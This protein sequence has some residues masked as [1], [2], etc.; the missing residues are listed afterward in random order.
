ME[1]LASLHKHGYRFLEKI[2]AG[3]SS[4]V[5]KVY[6]LKFA[7]NFAAKVMRSDPMRSAMMRQ[8]FE[9]EIHCLRRLSHPNIIRLYDHFQDGDADILILEYCPKGTLL[10]EVA[11]STGGLTLDRFVHLGPQ[12]MDA[13]VFSHSR[14]I[15]HRDVKPVNVFMDDLGRAKLADFG[16]GT[17]RRDTRRAGTAAYLAPEGWRKETCD[18]LKADVWALGVTFAHMLNGA[19]PWG[20]VSPAD[21]PDAI[22][23][24]RWA[25]E[26]ELPPALAA[27]IA[28][29]LTVDPAA[30]P[31]A[32][33]VARE[34]E[35]WAG[36]APSKRGPP[37][38]LLRSGICLVQVRNRSSLGRCACARVKYGPYAAV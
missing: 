36:P 14:G 21:L 38:A 15:A 18:A 16:M 19:L 23:A 26:R 20:R 35:A 37:R 12:I 31:T 25:V 9:A 2:G 28:R 30:R 7:E 24:A 27:L 5:Y 10:D 33:A 8:I 3:A 6:S 11:A 29:M 22:C 1:I 13:I 4:D 34:W 32:G 17:A